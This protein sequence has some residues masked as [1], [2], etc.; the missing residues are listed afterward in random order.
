ME[1]KLLLLLFLH[2]GPSMSNL[3]G[4]IVE[5]QVKT[6]NEFYAD[7]TFGH[8]D[9]VIC[10]VTLDG[11]ATCCIIDN[12]DSKNDDFQ[13]GS[14][15]SFRDDDLQGCQNFNLPNN[16]VNSLLSAHRGVDGWLGEF[17]IVMLDS[18][19]FYQCPI[20]GWLYNDEEYSLECTVKM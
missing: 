11:S 17:V 15:D 10:D 16:G 18:G 7:M 9:L 1:K 20:P 3:S 5:I 14:L 12:L 2:I 4:N 6:S 13:L 19:V 8:L